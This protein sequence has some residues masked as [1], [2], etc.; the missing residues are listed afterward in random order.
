M[1]ISD[2][3]KAAIL[4]LHRALQ[5]G[6]NGHKVTEHVNS[7]DQALHEGRKSRFAF[8]ELLIKEGNVLHDDIDGSLKESQAAR[9]IAHASHGR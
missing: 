5:K 1:Q 3:M 4:E 2:G 6:P 7:I 9:R 8:E